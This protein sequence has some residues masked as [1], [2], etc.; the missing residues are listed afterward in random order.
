MYNYNA[1]EL[2]RTLFNVRIIIKDIAN[3][4]YINLLASRGFFNLIFIEASLTNRF[5]HFKN[6]TA[7]HYP[8]MKSA[9][10]FENFI[11]LDEFVIK[12]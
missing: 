3:Y 10:N 7:R 6:R 2:V 8:R 4:S 9:L 1:E 11:L 12:V 5:K